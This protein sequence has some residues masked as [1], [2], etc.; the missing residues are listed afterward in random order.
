V[1]EFLLFCEYDVSIKVVAGFAAAMP[2]I[3]RWGTTNEEVA[4]SLPGDKSLPNLLVDWTTATTINARPDR[5][6]PWCAGVGL[7]LL[8]SQF[9]V[10]FGKMAV[11]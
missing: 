10:L 5:V 2:A 1:G 6:W 7:C 9:P 11:E 4:M 3:T 8:A